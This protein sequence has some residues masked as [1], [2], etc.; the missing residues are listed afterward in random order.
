MQTVCSLAFAA[1]SGRGSLER[2]RTSNTR[3]PMTG[4]ESQMM[5]P[6]SQSLCR[7]QAERDSG[8]NP[9][10]LSLPCHLTQEE[11]RENRMNWH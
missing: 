4:P 8:I 1:L 3:S 11:V 9:Y 2:A 5:N 10:S 6:E 7:S